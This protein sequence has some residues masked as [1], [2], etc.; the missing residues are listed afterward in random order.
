MVVIKRGG[1]CRRHSADILVARMSTSSIVVGILGSIGCMIFVVLLIIGQRFED[2]ALG[3]TAVFGSIVGGWW[4][5]V[6]QRVTVNLSSATVYVV[7]F[8]QVWELPV[9]SISTISS[10]RGLTISAGSDG[11][12][13]SINVGAVPPSLL[14][15]LRGNRRARDAV[16][17]ILAARSRSTWSSQVKPLASRTRV[18][19]IAIPLSVCAA[20]LA[21]A[22]VIGLIE[23]ILGWNPGQ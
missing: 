17:K 1:L 14:E 6:S 16:A 4:T 7:N 8:T 18:G 5:L 2:G 10:A 23:P 21:V 15:D 12:L 22:A 13:L 11:S 20:Y 19:L 3:I 9:W